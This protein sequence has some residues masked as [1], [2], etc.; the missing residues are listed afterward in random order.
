MCWRPTNPVHQV[1]YLHGDGI[2]GT[3][4]HEEGYVIKVISEFIIV[5]FVLFIVYHVSGYS[6]I[7]GRMA[8]DSMNKAVDEVKAQPDYAANGEVWHAIIVYMAPL[9]CI[10]N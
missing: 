1:G 9:M 3:W 4:I 6:D 5:V 10:V 8:E 2:C 7:V